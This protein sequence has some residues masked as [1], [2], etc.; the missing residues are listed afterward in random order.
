MSSIYKVIEIIGSSDKS[1]EDA[2][3]KAVET[4]A[5]TLEDLRVAE[6]KELD[7]RIEDGK[8]VEYRA[9]LRVSFK[10]KG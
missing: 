5:K 3:K 1:W 8:V 10:Y 2:A 9:K 6:V 4:A 7:M